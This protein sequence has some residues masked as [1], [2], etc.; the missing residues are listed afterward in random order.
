MKY[1]FD[2][3][4]YSIIKTET[5]SSPAHL[6]DYFIEPEHSFILFFI[7]T[8]QFCYHLLLFLSIGT[9]GRIELL[10]VLNTS[11]LEPRAV[12]NAPVVLKKSDDSP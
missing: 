8:F 11:A 3:Y 10:T 1:V 2:K 12:L 4:P 9:N 5:L 7:L 6:T